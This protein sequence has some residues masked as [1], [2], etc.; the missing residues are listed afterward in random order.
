MLL[1]DIEK[2]KD[3]MEMARNALRMDKKYAH[4]N[5]KVNILTE[6]KDQFE[7]ADHGRNLY[8]EY[9]EAIFESKLAIDMM[10]YKNLFLKL[11]ET[12]RVD[13]QKT[14]ANT[15]RTVKEIYEFVNIKPEL[16]GKDVTTKLLESTL[17]ES[18][19]KIKDVIME[20]VDSSF[21]QLTP[22]QRFEK[23]SERVTPLA[24][25][26]IQESCEA[27][28]SIQFSVKSV[29]MEDILT[30]IS[31]PKM[32]W[33]RVKHLCDSEDFGRI[34]DQSKLVE[35]VESFENNIK[36]LSKYVAASV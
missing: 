29:I 11:D 31:F 26:L 35:L 36:K 3:L 14:L 8:E 28:D 9:D 32:C 17:G 24:K 25:K 21:Y 20:A 16:F 2:E 34:F 18:E 1:C 12:Y 30:K 10:F 4:D 6:A 22:E 13:V 15:Y 33:T 19:K 23:Y 5:P 27:V 7:K